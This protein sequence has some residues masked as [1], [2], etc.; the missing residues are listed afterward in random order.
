MTFHKALCLLFAPSPIRVP[1]YP[2]PKSS[3][4]PISVISLSAFKKVKKENKYVKN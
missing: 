4:S 1:P 3:F 2:C